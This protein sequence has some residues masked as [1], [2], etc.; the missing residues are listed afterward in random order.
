M[1]TLLPSWVLL[2][3]VPV[4]R[5]GN[6][7][8]EPVAKEAQRVVEVGRKFRNTL[9]VAIKIFSTPALQDTASL[10]FFGLPALQ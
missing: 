8:K 3:L 10:L 1:L 2:A 5:G 4:A 6:V 9:H 7:A